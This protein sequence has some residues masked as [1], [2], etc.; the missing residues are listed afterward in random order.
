MEGNPPGGGHGPPGFQP[1]G[2]ATNALVPVTP[3]SSN[4]VIMPTVPQPMGQ[5]AE[6][7]N[8][9]LQLYRNNQLQTR[10]Q[11]LTQPPYMGYGGTTNLGQMTSNLGQLTSQVLVYK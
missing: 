1:I 8:T 3:S 4:N 2:Q 6:L 10:Q 9:L 11:M 5:D 7:A